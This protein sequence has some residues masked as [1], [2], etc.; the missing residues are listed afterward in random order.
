VPVVIVQGIL[1]L[2]GRA[3]IVAGKY[4]V[5]MRFELF[6]FLVTVFIV[7]NVYTE[8]KLFAWVIARKK[9]YQMAAIVF[10]A[11]VLYWTF[12]RD[13][14]K[15]IGDLA[16]K[17]SEFMKYLPLD[18]NTS[19][20]INPILDFTARADVRSLTHPILPIDS[21]QIGGQGV[22][23]NGY[24]PKT[25]RSV[26]ETRKKH[27]AAAQNWRCKHCT[28]QLTAYFE[29]DHVTPLEHGGSNEINNLEA[30]C[31]ECH[32]QKTHPP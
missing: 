12:R 8:G 28:K 15:N 11:L 17:S 9:Y 20:L 25:R 31:R 30:L 4:I 5:L 27:V 16:R 23:P 32:A 3:D 13:P 10:G 14:N 26:G 6:L 29:I 2:L 7:G 19:G 1:C 21:P 22:Q 24:P 18:S